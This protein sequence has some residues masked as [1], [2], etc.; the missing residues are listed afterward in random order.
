MPHTSEQMPLRQL[1][2]A[3]RQLTTCTAR[4]TEPLLSILASM[5]TG[6]Y[7][8]HLPKGA[9]ANPGPQLQLLIWDLP[10]I[11]L[12]RGL[13]CRVL[14]GHV[15]RLRALRAGLWDVQNCCQGGSRAD[16]QGEAR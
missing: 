11:C 13:K 6:A 9:N 2:L 5:W 10:L 12:P 14:D 8:P 1:A 4:V 7:A 3:R 16:L 15:R